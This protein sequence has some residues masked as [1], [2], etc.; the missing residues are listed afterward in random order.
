LFNESPTA[1]HWILT[2]KSG[3]GY[4]HVLAEAGERPL[5]EGVRSACL[6][7]RADHGPDYYSELLFAL[8]HKHYARESA[9]EIW[10][11]IVDH[12]DRLT[13]LLGR[14]PGIAVA[15]LDYLLNVEGGFGRPTLIDELKLAR[16]VDSATRDALTGLYDRSSLGAAL[17]RAFGE[18]TAPISAIMIDLD[19]FKRFNDDHGHLAGDRVLTRVSSIVRQSVRETDLPARYGG[20]ELCVVLPGRSL[21]EASHVADRLRARIEQEL[22]LEGVT[23]SFGVASF[24]EHAHDALSLLEAADRALYASKRSGRNR[25][26]VHTRQSAERSDVHARPSAERRDVHAR[27]SAERS[28]VHAR[29]SAERSDVHTRPSAERSDLRSTTRRNL[30]RA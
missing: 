16:L 3:L 1:E 27:P 13:T 24:P 26:T 5:D 12:R 18:G 9:P 23:A 21:E 8:T 20:E 25:V 2:T 28:D 29:P 11:R 15:A 4:E 10:S 22:E 7:L 14:N 6:R 17:Q 19:H 30:S